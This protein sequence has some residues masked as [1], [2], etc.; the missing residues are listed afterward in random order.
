MVLATINGG[1]YKFVL[2]LH[3]LCAIIGFGAVFLN[4]IYGQ[5]MKS[6]MQSGRGAEALAIYEA[7]FTVSKIGEYFIYAV[8]LLGFAVIGSQRLRV[9]VLPD[10]GLAL[11]G[12]LRRRPRPVARGAPARGAGAWAC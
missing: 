2:V 5:Q 8:F 4:G 10:L 12:A 11:G 9:E 6:R 1:F 3:I 7:N